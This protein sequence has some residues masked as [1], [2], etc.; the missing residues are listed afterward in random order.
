ME[1]IKEITSSN[2]IHKTKLNLDT[3]IQENNAMPHQC[4]KILE[5]FDIKL[6]NFF[7]QV[8]HEDDVDEV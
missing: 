7:L 1:N 5:N 6:F 4:T 3:K 8:F 2:D